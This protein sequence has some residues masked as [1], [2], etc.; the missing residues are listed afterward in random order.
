MTFEF[1]V[2][3]L[4]K[5]FRQG[6]VSTAPV[7]KPTSESAVCRQCV[8]R[9]EAL[10]NRRMTASVAP[11]V[12]SASAC[13]SLLVRLLSTSSVWFGGA[14]VHLDTGGHLETAVV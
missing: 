10:V 2:S 8:V 1:S 5:T 11:Q 4:V 3:A 6:C 9:A 14:L 7:G 13:E 12:Q